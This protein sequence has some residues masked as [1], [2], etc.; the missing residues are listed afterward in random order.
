MRIARTGRGRAA[1]L[2]AMALAPLA[3]ASL[4]T[5]A[6]ASVKLGS[7]VVGVEPSDAYPV[8]LRPS[9][10]AYFGTHVEVRTGETKQSAIQRVESEIGRRFAVDRQYERWGDPFPTAYDTWTSNQGRIPFIS[11]KPT[12][13]AGT[14]TWAQVA[15][16]DGDAELIARAD[17]VRAWGRP[18]YLSFHHE[19][20]DDTA[21]YGTAADFVAAFRHVVDVFRAEGATNAAW[22]WTMMGWSFQNGTAASFYPGDAYVDFVAVDAYNW[23]PGRPG[24]TW[25]SFADAV[26]GGRAFAQAHGVPLIVAEYGC[27]EDPAVPGRKAQWF[28]DELATVEGWPDVKAVLYFDSTK[29]YP[30]VTD[31]SASALAAY[32]AI[33]ADPYL[34]PTTAPTPSPSASVTGAPSASPSPAPSPTSAPT[35]SPDPKASATS[36]A[37]PSPSPSAS[38]SPSPRHGPAPHGSHGK[39]PPPKK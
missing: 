6:R 15:R 12:G 32:A 24:S 33:G 2:V 19:P 22:A 26:A 25:R 37:S 31:S 28:R 30:W 39:K 18:L 34:N 8:V 27:Q 14:L 35:P 10:G 7:T 1:M 17:A 9:Q 13:P 16:G 29:I 5:A 4:P 36:T 21:T 20:E 38:A 3:V 11:W 23:Y